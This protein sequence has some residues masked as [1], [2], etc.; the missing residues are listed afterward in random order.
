MITKMHHVALVVHDLDG[1]LHYY[2]D[3]LGLPLKKRAIIEEQAV[4]AALL[5]IGNSYIEI[6]QPLTE[7]SGVARFLANR[8]EGLH[9]VCFEVPDVMEEVQVLKALGVELVDQTPRP[10]LVG[11]V[12]FLH[13]RA[14]RGVLVELVTPLPEEEPARFHG[15]GNDLGIRRIDHLAFLVA[16]LNAAS[17]LWERVLG[18]RTSQVLDHSHD[19]GFYLGQIPIGESTIELLAP[20]SPDSPFAERL[21]RE[22]EGMGSTISVEV[23]DLDRAVHALRTKGVAVSDP[24]VGTLEGTRI[25]TADRKAG[26]GVSIQLLERV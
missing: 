15:P 25:A 24:R 7:E 6:I 16:D 4:E 2:R 19:R 14:M 1:A 18:L 20:S 12:A 3:V 26:H 17:E 5:S 23:T 21:A 8:G 22:G 9:H 11:Q 10:G 13:P